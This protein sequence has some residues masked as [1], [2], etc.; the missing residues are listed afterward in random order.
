MESRNEIS[1]LNLC[2][3]IR[4]TAF[5][6]HAYL[7]HGHFERVYENGLAHRLRKMGVKVEQ[8]KSLRIHDDDGTALGDYVMDL[9]IEN[10]LIVEVKACRTIVDEHIGQ[11]LGYLRASNHRDALIINFGSPKIQFRKLVW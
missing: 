9:V 6:L 4:Q 7:R 3:L 1:I 2:D 10:C 5:E 8:Q 11:V